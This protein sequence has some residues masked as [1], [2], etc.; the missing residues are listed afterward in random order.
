MEQRKLQRHSVISQ[1]RYC[2]VSR[3]SLHKCLSC[4]SSSRS[5][6]R[7]VSA[8]RSQSFSGL[9]R[10]VWFTETGTEKSD[11][12]VARLSKGEYVINAKAVRMFGRDFFDQINYGSMKKFADGGMVTPEPALAGAANVVVKNVNVF[13]PKTLFDAMATPRGEKL[14]LNFVTRNKQQM[15]S[16]L[17]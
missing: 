3:R 5:S 8:G 12:I 17:G 14:F 15:R 13:D 11:S 10:A 4:K 16:I 1:G 9:P 7:R 2:P 6:A